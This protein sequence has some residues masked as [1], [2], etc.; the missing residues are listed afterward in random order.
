MGVAKSEHEEALNIEVVL[1]RDEA[2]TGA[3]LPLEVP[4]F[5]ACPR[6]RG[7]GDDWLSTCNA[8][9][10]RGVTRTAA[11]VGIRIPPLARH[12]EV[13][14]TSLQHLGIHSFFLRLHVLIGEE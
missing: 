11:T 6:C 4:V 1:D 2:R 9:D 14:E 7:E 3:V 13:Y 5:Q 10:G 12:G 8:C